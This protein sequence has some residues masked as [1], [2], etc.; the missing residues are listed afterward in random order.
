MVQSLEGR[1]IGPNE[2]CRHKPSEAHWS[3]IQKC[4]DWPP[5]LEFGQSGLPIEK[6][7]GWEI[8]LIL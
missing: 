3:K 1:H 4:G 6:E 8:I 2:M 5:K 7:V